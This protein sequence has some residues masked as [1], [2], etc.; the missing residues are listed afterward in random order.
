MLVAILLL[1]GVNEPQKK[2][3]IIFLFNH[4][5]PKIIIRMLLAML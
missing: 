2:D 5:V 3:S 4:T 1:R